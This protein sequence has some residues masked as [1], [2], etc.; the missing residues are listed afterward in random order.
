MWLCFQIRCHS[1]ASRYSF[2]HTDR[3]LG[4]WKNFLN[5]RCNR[6][7]RDVA[8]FAADDKWR[9][10]QNVI[11]IYAIHAALRWIRKHALLHGSLKDLAGNVLVA[12]KWRLRVFVFNELDS[13]QQADATNI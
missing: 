3:T 4:R 13:R 5:R 1:R 12:R 7:R 9:R 10:Q 6:T 8:F 11:A 2:A